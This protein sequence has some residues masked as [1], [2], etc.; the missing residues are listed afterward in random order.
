MY[1]SHK[2]ESSDVESTRS[3]KAEE[4]PQIVEQGID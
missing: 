4:I 1:S 3:L 2:E